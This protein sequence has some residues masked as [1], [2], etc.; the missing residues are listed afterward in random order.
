MQV[1]VSKKSHRG[2]MS[3]DFDINTTVL[4][5]TSYQLPLSAIVVYLTHPVVIA[6]RRVSIAHARLH[7]SIAQ[8]RPFVTRLAPGIDL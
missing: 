8:Q 5:T 3:V 6:R 4:L 1:I 7:A 2:D